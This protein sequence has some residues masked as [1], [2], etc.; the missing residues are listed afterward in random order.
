MGGARSSGSSRLKFNGPISVI[1]NADDMYSEI[2][3]ASRMLAPD[4]DVTP[5]EL[6]AIW[7]EGGYQPFESTDFEDRKRSYIA[8]RLRIWTGSSGGPEVTAMIT[9]LVER[10]GLPYTPYERQSTTMTWMSSHPLIRRPLESLGN[11]IYNRTQEHFRARGITE[12]EVA[13]KGGLAERALFSSWSQTWSGVYKEGGGEFVR[14]WVPVRQVFSIPA[15]G[16]GN[17]VETEVVL[18][19]GSRRSVPAIF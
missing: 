15:T 14:A 4:W 13:R 2:D 19:P 12:I 16:F 5:E 8:G 7:L 9:P 3:I 17:R 18:L 6:N 10:L 11:L 1:S